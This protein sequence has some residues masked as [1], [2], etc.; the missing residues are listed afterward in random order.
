MRRSSIFISRVEFIQSPDVL[1]CTAVLQRIVTALGA[2]LIKILPRLLSFLP[3]LENALALK[4][5]IGKTLALKLCILRLLCTLSLRTGICLCFQLCLVGSLSC[6]SG[7]VLKY[8]LLLQF[9]H[10]LHSS[11]FKSISSNRIIC[12]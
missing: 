5:C 4:L 1:I 8:Q 12:E 9:L 11:N 10:C 2:R 6:L 3:E 7:T